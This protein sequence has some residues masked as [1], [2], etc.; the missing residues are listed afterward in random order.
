MGAGTED[1]PEKFL[2]ANASLVGGLLVCKR[3]PDCLVDCATVTEEG[4]G[5]KETYTGVTANT[6]KK[7]YGA[8]TTDMRNSKYRTSTCLSKHVWDL[9]DKG[10][11]FN[12]EWHLVDRSSSFNPITQKCRICL[13]EKKEI[14]YNTEGSSLNKRN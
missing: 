6:F 2:E 12:I 14:L 11:N 7:R 4:T 8:H 1:L 3:G 9:K 13:K 10:K 5:R